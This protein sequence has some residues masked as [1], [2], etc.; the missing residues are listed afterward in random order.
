MVPTYFL[1]KNICSPALGEE[2]STAI[3]V[4]RRKRKSKAT[5]AIEKKK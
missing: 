4:I 3:V 2:R 1:I 5:V